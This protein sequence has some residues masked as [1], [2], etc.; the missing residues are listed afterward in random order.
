MGGAKIMLSNVNPVGNKLN[1]QSWTL[2]DNFGFAFEE[3]IYDLVCEELQP[4]FKYGVKVQ[5]TSATRDDGK[6]IIITS[7]IEIL[8]LFNQKFEI[9]GKELSIFIECKSSNVGK[10]SYDKIIGNIEKMKDFPVDYVLLVTNTT[11]TPYTHYKIDQSLSEK[12][13]GFILIDQ[14]F[15]NKYFKQKG[16]RFGNQPDISNLPKIFAEYQTLESIENGQIIYNL[17][18]SV[19][20]YDYTDNL[21]S[22]HLLTDRNWQTDDN[23]Y[24]Q[25]IPAF[26]AKVHKLSI[27]RTASDGINDL[28]FSVSLGKNETNIQLNNKNITTTFEPKFM[29]KH[30]YECLDQLTKELYDAKELQVFYIWGEAGIGKSRIITELF[31][32]LQ[33][34][35]FDFGFFTAKKNRND[36]FDDVVTFLKNINYLNPK[37]KY[38]SL[39]DC[40]QSVNHSYRRA[41]LVFD[42]CHNC[43]KDFFNTIKVLDQSSKNPLSII[44]C[45]RNDYSAGDSNFFSFINWCEE[46]CLGTIIKPFEE[47]ETRNFIT[48]LINQAPEIVIKK[49]CQSSQN[50]P[51]YIVQYIEYLLETNLVSVVN[52]NTVGILNPS[53]FSSKVYIPN[54]IQNIYKKR[55]ENLLSLTNGEKCLQTLEI[56]SV[57]NGSITL[58]DALFSFD[59]DIL[60]ILADRRLIKIEKNN[61]VSLVHES[62]LI[63][64]KTTIEQ[65]I[66]RREKLSNILFNEFPLL[67]KELNNRE[68]GKLAYWKNDFSMAQKY[69]SDTISFL[70]TIENISSYNIDVSIYDYLLWIF[71]LFQNEESQAHLLK[72]ILVS[73]IYISLH[74][75]SPTKAINDCDTCLNLI[76]DTPSL[77]HNKNLI[78]SILEQKAHSMLNAGFV[79]D[80]ELI[81]KKL[82][83]NWIVEKSSFNQSTVFDMFDRLC[84]I[85]I[86]YNCWDLANYYNLCSFECANIIGDKKLLAIS[87]LTKNK[88]YLYKKKEI[89]QES[90]DFVNEIHKDGSSDRIFY[91]N[92]LSQLVLSIIYS[93]SIDWECIYTEVLEILSV[94]LK[95][96]FA[97]SIIR[98]Y[99]LLAISS[100]YIFPK[101][102]QY[103]NS[104]KYILKG[105]DACI[106]FGNSVHIWQFYNL[107]AIL[108]YKNHS[109]VNFI[110][111]LF[112]T[113]FTMLSKQNLLYFGEL[114]CCYG[115]IFAISNYGFF[116]QSH[117]FETEF[118]RKM[119]KVY[120]SGI[121]P[122]CDFNCSKPSCGYVCTNSTDL[123]R[124]EYI[125]ARDQKILF[126]DK[127]DISVFRDYDSNFFVVIS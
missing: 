30:H 91:S 84:G 88:L 89:A 24:S 42:D 96:N 113:V 34:T 32:R 25:I 9:K 44:L 50:I 52:R 56:L 46:N 71:K 117:D 62:F 35:Y 106:K 83:A 13:I 33:G 104:K 119:N 53:T 127:H 107:W 94:S 41:V 6:D 77:M 57:F 92:K 39:L 101:K 67:I 111:Q 125:K 58:E 54:E 16:K 122:N 90:I 29:G 87:Y 81:L 116:L 100:M 93:F 10:I 2:N 38:Y 73:L 1:I 36:S 118:Y 115:N 72:N 23:Y 120:Y 59:E 99:L 45:G 7:P 75:F 21:Y 61:M 114:D 97:T 109:N 124:R 28:L 86:K 108:E 48:T 95:N 76:K 80:G 102:K 43:S 82:Q 11:I 55:I 103:E 40:F 18:M 26:S 22:L 70:K 121:L 49:L 15:L 17:Y 51:L 66:Y 5:E 37:N 126:A 105:I 110:R 8:G 12:S 78:N 27:S 74:Y 47:N 79:S 60:N 31:K 112:E 4:L 20:N 123:L 64:L 3:Y 14:V 85:Y 68:L 63:F 69:F 19:K 98:A 65:S